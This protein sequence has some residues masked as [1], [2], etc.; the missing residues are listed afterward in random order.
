MLKRIYIDNYRCLV[1]FDLRLD[2]L[3]LLLGP[4]GSGKTTVFNALTAL[5]R[6]LSLEARVTEAFPVIA[7]T[8]WH[9]R[10]LQTFELDLE[11]KD[12]LF[13]YKLV[14]EHDEKRKKARVDTET[15]LHNDKPLFVFEHG[16]AHFYRDDYTEGPSFLFD[17]SQSGVGSMIETS[18]NEKLCWFRERVRRFMVIALKPDRM[19]TDTEVETEIL[20]PDGAN[21]ASWFRYLIQE[22]QDKIFDLISHL[23][24]VL[25]GFHGMR[26]TRAGTDYRA[27]YVGF[28]AEESRES[29]VYY[30]FNELS[31]GQRTLVVLYAMLFASPEIGYTLFIDEPDNYIALPEL[32]PW[33]MELR[34]ACGESVPQAVLISHHPELIDDLGPQCGTWIDRDPNQPTRVGR[35]P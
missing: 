33:L 26:L 10:P 23:R 22:Q 13:K 6:F 4:N 2:E 15:L 19:S 1:N 28:G 5:R 35:L 21:F 27:L 25:P 7:L 32:Q 9:K 24:D 34:D 11:G 29:L 20:E 31:D 3:S 18:V 8:R 17:W 12:G 14:I 16:T 30:R